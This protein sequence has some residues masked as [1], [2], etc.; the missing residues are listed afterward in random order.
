VLGRLGR[1]P[2]HDNHTIPFDIVLRTQHSAIIAMPRLTPLNEC[3]TFSLRAAA[4]LT[5]HLL[6]AVHFMES[7]TEISSPRTWSWTMMDP[8]FL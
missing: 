8:G 4:A 7:H 1:I 3:V 5:R 6:E 2:T